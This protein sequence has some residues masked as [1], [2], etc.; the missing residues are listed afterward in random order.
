MNSDLWKK[1]E[2]QFS[3]DHSEA[4]LKGFDF[5]D[6]SSQRD[7]QRH[8][9]HDGARGFNRGR[10]V[11]RSSAGA[12]ARRTCVAKLGQ[13]LIHGLVRIQGFRATF[14]YKEQAIAFGRLLQVLHSGFVGEHKIAVAGIP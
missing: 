13:Q 4:S 6:E 7:Y 5:Q 3:Q 9:I 14:G 10:A 11:S 8:R 1:S 2:P 12:P